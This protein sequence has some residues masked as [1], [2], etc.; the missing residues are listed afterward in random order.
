ML[1]AHHSLQF[2]VHTRVLLTLLV[3]LGATLALW[4]VPQPDAS[5]H[6]VSVAPPAH[7]ASTR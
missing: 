3:A 2:R 5:V 6:V 1:L 4:A 7:L